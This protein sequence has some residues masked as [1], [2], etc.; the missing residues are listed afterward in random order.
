MTVLIFFDKKCIFV[1]NVLNISG[2]STIGSLMLSSKATVLPSSPRNPFPGERADRPMKV[3]IGIRTAAGRPRV[4][5]HEDDG[6]SRELPLRLD[7]GNHSPG[8]EWGSGPGASQLALALA[9]DVLGHGR[10]ALAIA[11]DLKYKLI[12]RLPD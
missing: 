4:T 3:Y 10:Q 6:T 12:A 8:F 1:S 9:A 5:V 11:H 2:P 7:L